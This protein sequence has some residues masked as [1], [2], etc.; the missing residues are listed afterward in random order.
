LERGEDPGGALF[1]VCE[2]S[3]ECTRGGLIWTLPY[4]VNIQEAYLGLKIALYIYITHIHM[5]KYKNILTY[6]KGILKEVMNARD[7]KV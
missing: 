5:N 7:S 6:T 4:Y 3:R 2:E 1:Y